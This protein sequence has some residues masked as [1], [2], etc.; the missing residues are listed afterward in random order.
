MTQRRTVESVASGTLGTALLVAAFLTLVRA[1]VPAAA[2]VTWAVVALVAVFAFLTRYRPAT[3]SEA[4]KEGLLL[5]VGQTLALHGVLWVMDGTPAAP[6]LPLVLRHLVA[7]ALLDVATLA[8]AA[9]LGRWFPH[10]P[11]GHRR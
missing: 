8:T 3:L 2:V 6:T 11:S 4:V 7:F 5:A 10:R 1:E 9:V